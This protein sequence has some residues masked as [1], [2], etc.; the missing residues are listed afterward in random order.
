MGGFVTFFQ[1]LVLVDKA[2]F[3]FRHM[4]LSPLTHFTFRRRRG[5]PQRDS[6]LTNNKDT[7]NEGREE[8]FFDKGRL[9]LAQ[10]ACLISP[11]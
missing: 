5:F 2:D 11:L 9:G 10:G 1:P 4:F 6:W 8:A 7:G 3:G